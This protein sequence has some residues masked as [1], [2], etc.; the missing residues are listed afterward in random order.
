MSRLTELMKQIPLDELL[1]DAD[2]TTD[3][4]IISTESDIAET[5]RDITM[6]SAE[7]KPNIRQSGAYVKRSGALVSVAA[8]AIVAIGGAFAYFALSK[9]KPETY[10]ADSSSS[11]QVTSQP[12]S[13]APSASNK[14][15]R[16][17][18][19]MLTQT[20]A[21]VFTEAAKESVHC[22]R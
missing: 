12:A 3:N 2:N 21:T 5:T 9:N 10:S 22:S 11:A 20:A 6:T 18:F 19:L 14:A 13:Q 15:T 16:C 17:T 8:I 4:A 7:P 1:G